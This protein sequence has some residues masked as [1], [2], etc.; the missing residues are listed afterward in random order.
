MKLNQHP[1]VIIRSC[2]EY[3]IPTIRKIIREGLEE[4]DL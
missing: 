3:D 2:E 1:T 4:L